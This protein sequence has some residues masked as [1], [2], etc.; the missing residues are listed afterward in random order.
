MYTYSK[1]LNLFLFLDGLFILRHVLDGGFHAP[2]L[3]GRPQRT[4]QK[5]V[6]NLF[7]LNGKI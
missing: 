2:R 4:S 7:F 1:T 5:K 6:L 3:G